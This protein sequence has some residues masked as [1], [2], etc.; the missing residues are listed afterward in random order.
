MKEAAEVAAALIDAGIDRIEVPLNSPDPFSSIERMAAAHGNV[1]TIGAGTVLS[2]DQVQS[3]KDA[4]GQMIVSPNCFEDVIA[5][6]KAGGME[7]YPGCLTPSECFDAIRWGSDGLKIFPA[8][9]MGMKG[10]EAL[11]AV[12]PVETSVYMVGGVG[13]DNFGEWVKAGASG[14]GLGSWLYRPGETA[15]DVG[16]KARVAVAAWDAAT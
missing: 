3:V 10:L 6:T 8:F 7:S 14:F 1:A 2:V 11:R 15:E 4:G 13:P 12:L 5:A 16:E 9:Q